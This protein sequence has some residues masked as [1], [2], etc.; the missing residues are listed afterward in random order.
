VCN[1]SYLSVHIFRYTEYYIDV[2]RRT[3]TAASMFS[4]CSSNPALS[5]RSWSRCNEE[6]NKTYISNIV[7]ELVPCM[8]QRGKEVTTR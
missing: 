8:G 1:F 3:V 6:G 4:T 5:L 2:R 7:T